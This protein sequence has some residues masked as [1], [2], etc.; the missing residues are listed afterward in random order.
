MGI[1]AADKAMRRSLLA[2]YETGQT[3]ADLAAE[4]AVTESQVWD[5]ISWAKS[6]Q[7]RRRRALELRNRGMCNAD[8]G[9]VLVILERLAGHLAAGGAADAG[10]MDDPKVLSALGPVA[11]PLPDWLVQLPA[12]WAGMC[13]QEFL[14][15]ASVAMGCPVHIRSLTRKMAQSSWEIQEGRLARR[16]DTAMPEAA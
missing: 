1:S 4:L 8:I 13:R 7:L 14:I 5:C 6:E 11:E 16:A 12:D 10:R 15:R 2:R 3:L 9:Q